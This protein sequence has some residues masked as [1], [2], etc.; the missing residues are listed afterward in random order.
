MIVRE[1]SLQMIPMTRA[2]LSTSLDPEV[3]KTAKGNHYSTRAVGMSSR[4]GRRT[5]A[6]D[7]PVIGTMAESDDRDTGV[8]HFADAGGGGDGGDGGG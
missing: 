6:G 4:Q 3:R 2:L 8:E 7:Q 5:A 1:F